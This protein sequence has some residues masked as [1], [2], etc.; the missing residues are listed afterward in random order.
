MHDGF[1]VDFG[2][3]QTV[4]GFIITSSGRFTGSR[5]AERTNAV[6][7]NYYVT[8][9][10]DPALEH[11]TFIMGIALHFNSETA[12]AP[13]IRF[14]SDA[15][16]TTHIH[17]QANPTTR[18]I[19]VYRGAVTTLLGST[20]SLLLPANGWFFM[21][22]KVVL[23]DTNGSVEVR[24]NGSSTPVLNLTGINTKTVTGTKTV[25]DNIRIGGSDKA[26]LFDDFYAVNG[27][28]SAPTNTFLGDCKTEL[29][30][31]NAE[32]D[33]L[34]MSMSTGTTHY[35]LVDENPPSGSDY[36]F[37][38]V[39]DKIDVYNLTNLASTGGT[40]I[41]VSTRLVAAKSDAA[42]RQVADVLRSGGANYPGPD[43]VLTPSYQTFIETY[44]LNPA[45]GLAWTLADVNALQAGA[46]VR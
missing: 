27:A 6:T 18:A 7:T 33:V 10:V 23:H 32:G 13:Y 35:T 40:P 28:G 12:G 1:D 42:F 22:A 3:W 11:A 24:L 20:A 39:M 31:P 45:T 29:L 41:A 34:E 4:N 16:V 15:G 2:K 46:K 14:C 17:V 26:H 43:K 9:N 19:D 30:L 25:F 37:S 44:T 8:R 38:D 5:R 36:V 21:E